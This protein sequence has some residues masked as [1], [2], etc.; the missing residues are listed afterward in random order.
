W[1]LAARPALEEISGNLVADL[2]PRDAGADLDH[3]TG[4]IRQ[5]NDIV[6]HRQAICA[7]HDAEVAEVERPER[8]LDQHL[9]VRRFW[10]RPFDLAERIDASATLRQLPCTHVILSYRL[11]RRLN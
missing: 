5:R 7:A 2:D 1:R 9:A 10:I 4:D 11:I 8:D 3:L 6:A